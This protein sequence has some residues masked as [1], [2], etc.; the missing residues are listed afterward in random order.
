MKTDLFKVLKWGAALMLLLS[1]FS[2]SNSSD[3]KIS[4]SIDIAGAIGKERIVSLSEIADEVSVIPL[5]TG[6]SSIL[7][8]LSGVK[9]IIYENGLI[10][11]KDSRGIWIFG[12]DGKFVRKF[13]RKG[14]GP[15]EYPSLYDFD[16]DPK[17]GDIIIMYPGKFYEYRKDGSFIRKVTAPVIDGLNSHFRTEFKV[18]EN[19]YFC[20]VSPDDKET[21]NINNGVCAIAFDSL[22]NLKGKIYYPESASGTV[23]IAT[24]AAFQITMIGSGTMAVVHLNSYFFRY[25]DNIRIGYKF[26]NI[27]TTVNERIELDTVYTINFGDFG[28]NKESFKKTWDVSSKAITLTS[29]SESDNYLFLG[30]DP[31]GLATNPVE[32]EYKDA[33]GNI[34]TRKI[35]SSRALFNKKTGELTIMERPAEDKSGFKDDLSGGL[36]FWPKYISS[37]DYLVSHYSAQEFIEYAENKDASEKI[38][39]IAAKLDENDNPVVVLVKLK[40]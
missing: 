20:S 12:R 2:C 26:D 38:K 11:I 34:S 36:V 3:S 19:L 25:K 13:S 31:R 40:N 29:T 30:V 28:V 24:Q 17:T 1:I 27:I 14:R 16:V 5:E 6:D 10:Y 23:P 18:K 32:K 39:R 7:G 21:I 15:Q 33:N 4:D 22:S 35:T 9:D 8:G 37:D